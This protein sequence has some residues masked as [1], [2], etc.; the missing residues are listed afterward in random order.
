ML[1]AVCALLITI[2][3]GLSG[4]ALVSVNGHESRMIR[5]ETKAEGT[6]KN[7]DEIKQSLKEVLNRLPPKP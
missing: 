1:G 2:C 7:L 4:W 6:E 3:L 5:V